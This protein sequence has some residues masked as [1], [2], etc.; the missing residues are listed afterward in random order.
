MKRVLWIGDK[1]RAPKEATDCCSV[2]TSLTALALEAPDYDIIL[3]DDTSNPFSLPHILDAA[4][5]LRRQGIAFGVVASSD[6][7]DKLRKRG[8]PGNADVE[9]LLKKIS[10][11]SNQHNPQSQQPQ[12][13]QGIADAFTL[14]DALQVN[15][16]GAQGRIGCTTQAFR[17]CRYLCELGFH[18]AVQPT[19]EQMDTLLTL[20]DAD[21]TVQGLPIVTA[22]SAAYNC[23]IRDCGTDMT[24]PAADINV[25]VCGVKVWEL[26][27][28]VTALARFYSALRTCVIVSY[29]DGGQSA[30]LRRLCPSAAMIDAPWQPDPFAA[31][32]PDYAALLPLLQEITNERM[33]VSSC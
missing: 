5:R 30:S 8:V 7:R 23:C 29:G 14:G 2:L 13:L 12:C 31:D 17:L 26:P 32:V 22:D 6:L 21:G 27:Q 28:S 20:V 10:E 3:L 18:A 9:E 33:E 4:A 16:Y 1:R 15:V 25:L 24:V 19:P 11:K